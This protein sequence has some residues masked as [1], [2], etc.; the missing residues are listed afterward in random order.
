MY[1]QKGC[2]ENHCRDDKPSVR[3]NM[4]LGHDEK[5]WTTNL[6]PLTHRDGGF[7]F[8]KKSPC[9]FSALTLSLSSF[10]F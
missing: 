1:V 8:I 9:S 2:R 4:G 3:W 10:F 7:F 6:L 5:S